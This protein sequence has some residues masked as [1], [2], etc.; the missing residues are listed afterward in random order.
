MAFSLS[1]SNA[2]FLLVFI[3]DK[4]RLKQFEYV[5]LRVISEKISIPR[6]TLSKIVTALHSKGIIETKEG[7]NGGIRLKQSFKS[8]TLWDIFVAIEG[9]KPLFPVVP[10][11]KAQGRRPD[12]VRCSLQQVFDSSYSDFKKNLSKQKFSALLNDKTS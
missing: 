9:E 2:L 11:I 6:P 12:A 7:K 4:I 1:Y 5:P 10:Q 3:A 8:M